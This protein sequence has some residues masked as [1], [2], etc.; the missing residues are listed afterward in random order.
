MVD[1]C[2]IWQ[3]PTYRVYPNTRVLRECRTWGA[4]LLS[5]KQ[6]GQG[7]VRIHNRTHPDISLSRRIIAQASV[8]N[9]SGE[10]VYGNKVEFVIFV[11]YSDK[12]MLT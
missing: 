10:R 12:P 2:H 1:I 4:R 6:G 5:T 3:C 9:M 7:V 11:V 8:N